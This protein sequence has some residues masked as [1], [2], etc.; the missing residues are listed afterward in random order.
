MRKGEKALEN[1][2]L[3]KWCRELGLQPAW[4]FIWGFPREPIAEYRRMAEEV[5][6]LSHL[7]PPQ[8][9]KPIRLDRFSPNFEIGEALGFTDIE[10]CPAYAHVYPFDADALR[11]LAY[12]FAHRHQDARDVRQYTAPLGRAVARWQRDHADSELFQVAQGD[13]LWIW[14]LRPGG[15]DE[16]TRLTGV[17]RRC[18][19]ACDRARTLGWLAGHA[20]NGGG[21]LPAADIEDRLQPLVAAGIML[22]HDDRFLSLAIPGNPEQSV[23]APAA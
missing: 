9:A 21:P 4:N 7:T 10:P 15:G 12:H 11:N 23:P 19:E 1:I 20:G 14:D 16:L 13:E 3:L 22:R 6:L 18:Y 5:P 17:E 2:Q 8:I